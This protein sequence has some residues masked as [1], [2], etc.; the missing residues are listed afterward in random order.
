MTHTVPSFERGLLSVNLQV[1][2]LRVIWKPSRNRADSFI[3]MWLWVLWS[4][5][6]RNRVYSAVSL[7]AICRPHFDRDQ[8]CLGCFLRFLLIQPGEKK[9]WNNHRFC[10]GQMYNYVCLFSS[11]WVL[12]TSLEYV[13]ACYLICVC[14]ERQQK[15]YF[16]KGEGN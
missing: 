1:T 3:L 4:Y 2:V 12:V 7:Q 10:V 15:L 5:T 8:L 9:A 11:W 6:G 14:S 16:K 13:S